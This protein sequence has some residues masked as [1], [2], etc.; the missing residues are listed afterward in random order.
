MKV[1]KH[2]R[3]GFGPV[4]RKKVPCHVLYLS[5][6]CV[7]GGQ[8][9]N[10]IYHHRQPTSQLLR[11]RWKGN[12]RGTLLDCQA[13]LRIGDGCHD[14]GGPPRPLK[15]PLT[16]FCS[17]TPQVLDSPRIAPAQPTFPKKN[18]AHISSIIPTE[19]ACVQECCLLKMVLCCVFSVSSAGLCDLTKCA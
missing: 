19:F 16:L 12:R 4:S 18:M 13:A 6:V 3:Q 15:Q 7:L 9:E 14:I 17:A 10:C 2:N 1:P 11:T 8:H 5:S